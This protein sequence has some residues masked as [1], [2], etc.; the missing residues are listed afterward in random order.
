MDVLD[1]YAMLRGFHYHMRRYSVKQYSFVIYNSTF[2]EYEKTFNEYSVKQINYIVYDSLFL[3]ISSGA[4]LSIMSDENLPLYMLSWTSI[5]C[6]KALELS[7]AI[8][9]KIV[10]LDLCM[11]IASSLMFLRHFQQI[12]FVH[13]LQSWDGISLGNLS[14]KSGALSMFVYSACMLITSI[15]LT[16]ISLHHYVLMH[17]HT[18]VAKLSFSHRQG[19]FV[20]IF[21]FISTNW[22]SFKS[23]FN[24][25][26]LC[27]LQ[28]RH[29][30]R[31]HHIG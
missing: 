13:I 19:G 30:M 28:S 4:P 18:L 23:L 14:N 9:E 11:P 21:D 1:V 24:K 6:F 12:Y 26:I 8:W 5:T 7:Q 29:T 17:V 22:K 15:F 20:Q 27:I 3:C 25:S 31:R 16:K 10:T 2:Y